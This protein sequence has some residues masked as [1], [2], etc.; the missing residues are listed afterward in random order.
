MEPLIYYKA[1]DVGCYADGTFGHQ[2]CRSVLADLVQNIARRANRTSASTFPV[3]SMSDLERSLRSDM[4]DDAWD[5]FD[6]IDILNGYC[7]DGV[8]FEFVGGDLVLM[9]LDNE[10]EASNG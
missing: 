6:A 5:E 3:C 10:G 2:H 9:A 8:A 1:S 7:A 4:P